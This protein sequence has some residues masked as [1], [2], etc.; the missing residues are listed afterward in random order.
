MHFNANVQ[1]RDVHVNGN[2]WDPTGP[3]H[4]SAE[5]TVRRRNGNGNKGM[6]MGITLWEWE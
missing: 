3:I 1:S 2:D 4:G 6:G 5:C